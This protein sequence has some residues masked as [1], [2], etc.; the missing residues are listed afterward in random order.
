VAVAIVSSVPDASPLSAD[1]KR[2]VNPSCRAGLA[3]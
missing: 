2:P 1:R 3:G